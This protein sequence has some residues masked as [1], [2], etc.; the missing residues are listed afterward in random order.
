[1]KEDDTNFEPFWFKRDDQ[2]S[3]EQYSLCFTDVSTNLPV[4]LSEKSDN[5][6]DFVTITDNRL[7]SLIIIQEKREES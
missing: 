6:M 5:G 2:C 7:K 4:Y 3:S 1:M